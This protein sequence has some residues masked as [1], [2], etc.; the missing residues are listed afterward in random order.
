MESVQRMLGSFGENQPG[1]VALIEWRNNQG[2]TSIHLAME[3]NKVELAS[4]FIENFIN[5]IDITK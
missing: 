2:K 3:H 1:K 5:E 4:Y